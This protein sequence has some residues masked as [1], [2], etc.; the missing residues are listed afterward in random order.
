MKFKAMN[1]GMLFLVLSGFFEALWN[2]ALKKTNG[3]NDWGLNIIGVLFLVGSILA[4][5]KAI[6][7]IPLSIAIV[8]WSGFSLLLTILFDMYLFKTKI[9][10]RTALFMILCI[11]SII[12]LNYYS[13]K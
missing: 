11:T 1:I 13:T 12:G 7:E 4:F 10:I 6:V 8:I 5:K 2:I 9:D 3:L